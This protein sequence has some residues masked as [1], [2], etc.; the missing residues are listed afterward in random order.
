MKNIITISWPSWSWKTTLA[1]LI[2]DKF[3]YSFPENYTTRSPR[4][5]DFEYNHIR[6]SQYFD[7]LMNH[8]LIEVLHY[9]KHYYGVKDFSKD[10]IVMAVDV[11]WLT[12]IMKYAILHDYNHLGIYIDIEDTLAQSRMRNRWEDEG[13]IAERTRQD[14]FS[15]LIGPKLCHLVIDWSWTIEQVFKTLLAQIPDNSL[16][17]FHIRSGNENRIWSKSPEYQLW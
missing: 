6:L 5:N 2:A 11:L 10:N 14:L 16:Y 3:W 15:N 12:Q 9:N 1:K 8:E 13:T 17:L 7:M 4:A